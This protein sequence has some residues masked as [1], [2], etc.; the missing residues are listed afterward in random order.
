MIAAIN[1]I[2]P[3]NIATDQALDSGVHVWSPL[4]PAANAAVGMA[5]PTPRAATDLC[6]RR[7]MRD[8]LRPD[9]LPRIEADGGG[10]DGHRP[11]HRIGDVLRRTGKL[12]SAVSL[13][14]G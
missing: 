6:N 3:R 5:F 14:L 9:Q 13:D 1:P 10:D 7:A 11:C 8:G 2:R 12:M 4:V